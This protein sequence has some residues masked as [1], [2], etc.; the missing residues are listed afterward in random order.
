MLDESTGRRSCDGCHRFA[1]EVVTLQ[2]TRN[3][4]RG[5]PTP[6]SVDVCTSC[7]RHDISTAVCNVAMRETV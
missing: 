3:E 6:L 5:E 1:F 7:I 2:V 4:I